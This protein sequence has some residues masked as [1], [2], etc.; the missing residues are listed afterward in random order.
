M[1]NVLIVSYHKPKE[2][3]RAIESVLHSQVP[4]RI[5]LCDQSADDAY[6]HELQSL[7]SHIHHEHWYLQSSEFVCVD[8]NSNAPLR[9]IR[10]KHNGGFAAGVNVLLR[11]CQ[12]Q[13]L[14]AYGYFLLNDD[15]WLEPT[16]LRTLALFAQE[17]PQA[18]IAGMALY[19]AENPNLLQTLGGRIHPI[20]A[21]AN[22]I[23]QRNQIGLVDYVNGA[24]MYISDAAMV[25]L[26]YMD[27]SFF[28]Y[29]EETDYCFRARKMNIPLYVLSEAKVYHAK[30]GKYPSASLD[31][32]Q[33]RN[34]LLFARKH[35]FS[36]LGVR[37]GLLMSAI[38][39]LK[40]GQT[41]QFVWVMRLVFHRTGNLAL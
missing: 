10:N 26:G 11:F 21:T 35:S 24:A 33:L 32:M 5:L 40:R 14:N 15:A 1:I 23:I 2:T 3:L 30:G 17:H 29:Y 7:I 16:A 4:V 27:E 34:R 19:E 36:L 31:R 37:F 8:I 18:V 12:E 38:L 20:F 28:M 9:Y 6:A 25:Q 39:R 22:E 13:S 41:N